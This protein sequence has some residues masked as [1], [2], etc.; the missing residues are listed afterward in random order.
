MSD[1]KTFAP[2]RVEL[3]GN[4]TDYNGGVVLSAAIQM[5]VS[6]TGRRRDD[7]RIVLTSEGINGVVAVNRKSGLK[8]RDSW[9]DYPLGVAEM[10]AKAGATPGGFE[11]NF[12]ATLPLGAGLSSSAALDA[13]AR[14]CTRF[15]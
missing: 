5:G 7:D 6:A 2:G 13:V 1:I 4:H 11:A 14:P 8:P 9:E 3:L 15:W 12:S 10:L